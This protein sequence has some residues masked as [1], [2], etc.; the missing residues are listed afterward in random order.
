MKKRIYFL[1]IF[2]A[3]VTGLH[4]QNI[5][6]TAQYQRVART[7]PQVEAPLENTQTARTAPG[8]AMPAYSTN[9]VTSTLIGQSSNT[10]GYLLNEQRQLST[11]NI[12]GTNGGSVSFIFRQNWATCGTSASES[13][14]LRYNLSTDGGQ[15]WFATQGTCLGQGPLQVEYTYYGRYPNAHLFSSGGTAVSDLNLAYVAP[16]I[17]STN[18]WSGALLGTANDLGNTTQPLVNQEDYV[19]SSVAGVYRPINIAERVSGEF[20]C[21][22][23]TDAN[24][25]EIRKGLWQAATQNI[26]WSVVQTFALDNELAIN[27]DGNKYLNTGVMTFSPDGK[28]GYL[29]MSGDM[30]G[31]WDNCINPIISDYNLSTGLFDAP[32]E[33]SFNDMPSIPAHI[34]EWTDSLN[35]PIADRGTMINSTITTDFRGNLHIYALITPAGGDGGHL[36]T[37]FGTDV[38]DLT[39]DAN[40]NW[41]TIHISE[42]AN[43]KNSFGST[44]SPTT[45]FTFANITRSADG[46]YLM[47]SWSDTD[48]TGM[49]GIVTTHSNLKGRI[50][51]VMANKISPIKDWTSNDAVWAGFADMPK[52][53]EVALEGSACN[54][55]VP[56]TI[57]NINTQGTSDF[58]YFSDVVYNCADA[59][60]TIVWTNNTLAIQSPQMLASF[61]LFPNPAT[62]FV[63]LKIAFEQAN[64][65]AISF[66]NLHGQILFSKDLRNVLNLK[67]EI[68]LKDL[69]KGMYYVQIRTN[70]GVATRKLV[71]E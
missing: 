32:Y 66:V 29:V 8:S 34:K 1:A 13:G 67:E 45:Y 27:A 69:P 59:T 17:S 4:A 11:V 7:N 48:T 51:D 62:N 16:V 5:L 58:Y 28:K 25:V 56:T 18:T 38:Y 61:E 42:I 30:I 46:K 35:V 44:A 63:T 39:K 43:A 19:S 6:H 31:G 52:T 37:S 41:G 57:M 14:I 12:V 23:V 50:Y 2:F 20:W 55:T 3:A 21:A 71:V 65:V 60:D 10:A 24:D 54:F 53:S 9:S 22:T 70:T 40:G 47:Y 49:N 64:T 33:L 68:S 26:A 15:S 36:Y